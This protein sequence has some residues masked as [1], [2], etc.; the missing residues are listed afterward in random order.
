MELVFYDHKIFRDI[1]AAIPKSITEGIF[2]FTRDGSDTQTMDTSHV[3]MLRIVLLQ[4]LFKEY[5]FNPSSGDKVELKMNFPSLKKILNANKTEIK[6]TGKKRKLSD[7]R[8]TD[9]DITKLKIIASDG[10]D[11]VEFKF[12]TT[13]RVKTA[14]LKLITID[15][16]DE[17]LGIPD[18]DTC[19]CKVTMSAREFGKMCKDFSGD[20]LKFRFKENYMS[21]VSEDDSINWEIEYRTNDDFKIDFNP[22]NSDGEIREELNISLARERY[23]AFGSGQNLGNIVY[24]KFRDGIP[25]AVRYNIKDDAENGYIEYFLAPKIAENDDHR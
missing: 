9:K 2:Y 4:P 18:D 23:A 14:K 3:N 8:D 10:G 25:S 1:A 17:R 6:S 7:D 16:N 11:A 12:E 19:D 22:R 13:K 21:I 24:L 15:D 20:V 5:K